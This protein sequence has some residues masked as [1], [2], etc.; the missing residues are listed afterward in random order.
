MTA[1]AR[2]RNTRTALWMAGV[3]AVMIGLVAISPTLYRTFCSLTGFGGTPLRAERAPGAV[4]GQVGVRF[5]AN[6]HP[7]L[8]WRFDYH[9]FDVWS[10]YKRLQLIGTLPADVHLGLETMARHF[11]IV[12]DGEDAHRAATDIE[13]TWRLYR[14]A[15]ARCPSTP[16]HLP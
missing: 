6:V 7:G 8:P 10:L 5:D 14:L 2:Q 13:W 4:A 12:R 11:N 9:I 16:S 15:I 3:V 1:L